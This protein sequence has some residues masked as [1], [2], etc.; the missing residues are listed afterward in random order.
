MK[1]GALHRL[2]KP[3]MEIT[4]SDECNKKKR[5]DRIGSNEWREGGGHNR[6]NRRE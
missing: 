3:K 1:K 5:I 2:M 4:A 6:D